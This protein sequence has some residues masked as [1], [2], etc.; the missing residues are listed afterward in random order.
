M[1]DLITQAKNQ[2][3]ERPLNLEKKVAMDAKMESWKNCFGNTNLHFI[4]WSLF[5]F[6]QGSF[7]GPLE[8]KLT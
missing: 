8:Q 1:R 2:C 4:L 6:V 7:T 5:L 3:I